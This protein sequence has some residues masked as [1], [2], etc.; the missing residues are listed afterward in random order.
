M[1]ALELFQRENLLKQFDALDVREISYAAAWEMFLQ[2]KE[3]IQSLHV[4]N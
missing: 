4:K 2:E 3:A 1:A